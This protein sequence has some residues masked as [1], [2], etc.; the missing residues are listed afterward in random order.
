MEMTE[1][2]MDV[3]LGVRRRAKEIE[4]VTTNKIDV[5]HTIQNNRGGM[6]QKET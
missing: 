5:A 4:G 3:C 6:R 1:V 2:S